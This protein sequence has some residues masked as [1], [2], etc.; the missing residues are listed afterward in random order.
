MKL[1]LGCG[2]H[3]RK[4]WLNVDLN[5][6][7]KVD[8]VVNLQE[9]PLPFRDNCFTHIYTAHTIEHIRGDLLPLMIELWR[10]LK[11]NGFLEIRV[12]HFSHYSSLDGFTHKQVF[13]INGFAAMTDLSFIDAVPGTPEFK[14]PLFKLVSAKLMHQRVED[15]NQILVDKNFYYYIAKFISFL[16]NLNTNLC[17]KIWCYWVG[18]FQ[19]M[20]IVLK[21]VPQEMKLKNKYWE[22]IVN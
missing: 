21:K 9:M 5:N 8:K 15:N 14:K 22:D 2:T 3:Y 13:S 11:P 4:G 17:E 20:Q 1:H 16:A 10:I 18:G 19:E 6:K 7:C 12:P